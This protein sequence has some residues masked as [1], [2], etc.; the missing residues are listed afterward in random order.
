[1]PLLGYGGYIPFA[2]ELYALKNFFWPTGPRLVSELSSPTTSSSS[3][4]H[5]ESSL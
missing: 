1:M 5:G 2:L 3:G 4:E